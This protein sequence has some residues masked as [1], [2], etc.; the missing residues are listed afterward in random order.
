MKMVLIVYNQA[1][2]EEIMEV[3]TSCCLDG[4]TKWQRVLGQGELSEPHLDT[5]V[6]PG[7]NNVCMAVV[8]DGAVRPL[9]QKIGELRRK[10][11]KEGV[12]AFVLPVE[13][14]TG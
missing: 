3:L 4:F 8:E 6:W 1:V 14:V 2:D 9:I 11:S 13:E 7:T 12:K 5:S 10:L